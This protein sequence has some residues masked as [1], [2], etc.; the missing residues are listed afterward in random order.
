M[1]SFFKPL[2]LDAETHSMYSPQ[3]CL[4]SFE[5]VEAPWPLFNSQRHRL[6]SH[7]PIPQFTKALSG[8]RNPWMPQVHPPHGVSKAFFLLFLGKAELNLSSSDKLC[9]EVP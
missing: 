4:S 2:E 1:G 5:E 3:H 9:P 6:G 8:S 7:V